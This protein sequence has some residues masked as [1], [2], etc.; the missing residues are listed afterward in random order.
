MPAYVVLVQSLDCEMYIADAFHN[1]V[2]QTE[3]RKR[4][5]AL[6][7]KQPMQ[8]FHAADT[9]SVLWTRQDA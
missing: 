7:S 3:P 9:A 5:P 2:H 8:N 1:E 4:R 6:K